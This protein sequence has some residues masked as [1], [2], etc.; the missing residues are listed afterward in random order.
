MSKIVCHVVVLSLKSVAIV[1]P[2]ID[3][4]EGRKSDG[5]TRAFDG[6]R[7]RP[8]LAAA[9]AAV[10]PAAISRWLGIQIKLIVQPDKFI[11]FFPGFEE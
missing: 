2:E 7:L 3:E 10:F 4:L 1:L 6:A 9:S 5:G 11:Y 8:S